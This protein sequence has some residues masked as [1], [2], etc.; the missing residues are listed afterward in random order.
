MRWLLRLSVLA[1]LPALPTCSTFGL[2]D[3]ASACQDPRL[4]RPQLF[5][6]EISTPNIRGISE[7]TMMCRASV[8]A[9]SGPHGRGHAVFIVQ[10]YSETD[11]DAISE[12]NRLF[13]LTPDRQWR[14]ILPKE[15]PNAAQY[16]A[17]GINPPPDWLADP[18]YAVVAAASYQLGDLG[19]GPLFTRV[20]LVGIEEAGDDICFIYR[21]DYPLVVRG[22]SCLTGEV[23]VEA[24]FAKD[25][26]TV[27]DAMKIAADVLVA[28]HEIAGGG[29]HLRVGGASDVVGGISDRNFHYEIDLY[30]EDHKIYSVIAVDGITG[31]TW[32]APAFWAKGAPG[33]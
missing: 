28:D 12:W 14:E 21:T 2:P 26:L 4:P 32:F 6:H 22:L 20:S 33:L 5:R 8:A 9:Y 23:E 13:L 18:Q 30:H 15:N 24:E 29:G 10:Q 19:F 31:R 11:I 27:A 1:L 17:V 7:R 3:V 25:I 16:R